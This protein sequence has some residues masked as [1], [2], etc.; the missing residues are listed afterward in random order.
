MTAVRLVWWAVSPAYPC[1]QGLNDELTMMCIS[2]LL[3]VHSAV[4]RVGPADSF[5]PSTL[6]AP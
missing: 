5:Q 1:A 2:P 3:S 6:G 4:F